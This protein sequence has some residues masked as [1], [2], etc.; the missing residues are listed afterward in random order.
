MKKKTGLTG[1]LASVLLGAGCAA[2]IGA[3]AAYAAE[4]DN[5]YVAEAVS[6]E[7]AEQEAPDVKRTG[8]INE[9]GKWYYFRESGNKAK[10]WLQDGDH[11]Y[12]LDAE[13]VMKTGWQ[14]IGERWYYFRDN[15][16]MQTG[17]LNLSGHL[18]YFG[19]S[20]AMK[21][22]WV[23]WSK[24]WYFFSDKGI[25]KTG[26]V[27]DND[28]LY[29]MG[30]DG[31]LC[32]DQLLKW[33]KEYYRLNDDGEAVLLDDQLAAGVAYTLDGDLMAAFD[34]AVNIEYYGRSEFDRTWTTKELSEY[35]IKN[36]KGNCYVRSAVFC[37]LAV[38]MGYDA[39][40]ITGYVRVAGG[41]ARHGWVEIVMD[42]ETFV[43][44]PY[45]RY[46]FGLEGSYLFHYGDKGTY[47]YSEPTRME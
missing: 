21:T 34:Y 16:R 44:D 6:E 45:V 19:K 37:N 9:D 31:K 15:G 13:G 2:F 30:K 26:W 42:G 12:Y 5:V 22:G 7:T 24:N 11:W 41:Y 29:Y 39:R 35:G 28:K 40:M 47:M 43:C 18:Y 17:W 10:G 14:Q 32:R 27:T 25:M 33:R 38:A 23:K 36:R 20:G 8:W 46:R 3:P 4:T 1:M